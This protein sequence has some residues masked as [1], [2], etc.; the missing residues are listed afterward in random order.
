MTSKQKTRSLFKTL[1]KNLN[2]LLL[3]IIL[4]PAVFCT[5]LSLFPSAEGSNSQQIC[6]IVAL[7]AIA[8]G[9]TI[10]LFNGFFK[11]HDFLYHTYS[12][13]VS[14]K[15]ELGAVIPLLVLTVI[16][17]FPFYLLI[18]TSL[19]NTFEANSVDFSWWPKEGID[20]ASYAELM[21]YDTRMGASIAK[22]LLNS[23]IYAIVPTSVGLFSSSLAA[24]AF[25]KLRFRF[26]GTMYSL[27]IATM[28]MPG[29][30]TLST[31][32][33]LYSWYGWTNSPLPLIIPGLFG[34]ASCVMFLREFFM[35]IPNGL[36]EAAEIDGAGKWRSYIHI[37]LPLARPALTAQFILGFISGFNDYLG[38][39]IYLNDPQGYSVQIFMNWLNFSVYDISVIASAGVCALIP[40][41]LLYIFFQKVILKGISISS[42]LKG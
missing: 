7:C 9:V 15:L 33:L 23:F 41:L 5:I 6:R 25:S 39:L 38:P 20:L 30:V 3:P 13:K 27:L 40:M 36:L 11:K 31:S 26:K 22:S 10:K 34:S 17:I 35:G 21:E 19:K 14:Q 16:I 42:G 1:I 32:Y 8:L 2:D 18:V 37:L 28:M 29:C 24:Y 12:F 4:V